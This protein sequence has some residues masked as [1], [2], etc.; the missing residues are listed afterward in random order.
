MA[1]HATDWLLDENGDI[2][3]ALGDFALA[4]DEAGIRQSI[5]CWLKFF[6]GEWFLD[7]ARGMPYFQRIFVKNPSFIEVR[8]HFR[9]RLAAVPGV[10]EILKLDLQNIGRRA[11]EVP[12]TVNT[13]VGE[14][15]GKL[16]KV[17]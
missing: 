13:D 6:E 1:T 7:L 4:S 2:V 10:K 9:A 14:L 11:V 5:A 17:I 12:W 15:S 8:E 16:D 3:I